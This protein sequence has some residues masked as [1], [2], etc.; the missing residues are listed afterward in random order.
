METDH[1][2]NLIQKDFNYLTVVAR[3]FTKNEP[4]A[5]DL[6]QET[7]YKALKSKH[8]FKPDTN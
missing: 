1:F 4:D 6:F 2:F 8:R 5:Q 7:I 3:K